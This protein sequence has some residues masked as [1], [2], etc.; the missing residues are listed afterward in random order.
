MEQQYTRITQ[1]LFEAIQKVTN[2]EQPKEEK[3]TLLVEEKNEQQVETQVDEAMSADFEKVFASIPKGVEVHMKHKDSGEI[4][5]Q[6][7]IGTHSAVAAAKKHIASMEKKGYEIHAKKLIEQVEIDESVEES[8]GVTD[9]N[10]KSQGGTRKELLAKYH[11]TK[12]P[13]DAEAARKAG[14]TQ[15]ELQSEEVEDV[16]EA[17]AMKNMSDQELKNQHDEVIKKINAKGGVSSN[18]RLAQKARTIRTVLAMRKATG[19]TKENEQVED[20][21][22]TRF[23]KGQDVGA[24]GMNFKK[25]AASAAKRYGSKEAGNRVAGA[26]LKKVMAKEE[27]EDQQ[28]DETIIKEDFNFEAPMEFTFADYLKAA[29][30]LA[31]SQEG[32]EEYEIVKLAHDAFKV[33]EEELVLEELTRDDLKQKM[34][35]HMDAGHMISGEK[36]SMKDGKPYGEYVVTDK[37]TGVR[38]KYIHHGNIRRVEN[39]GTRT[40]KDVKQD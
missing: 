13:K 33:Q 7:F 31:E 1:S 10:P 30:S 23:K 35:A 36:F 16:D 34:K 38:R 37:E 19:M 11:K 17:K 21:D 18:D 22:E 5:K 6:K 25:I 9:Y 2:P 8:T 14:A 28:F 32:V 27:D 4:H 39:M 12:N 40:K 24:P 26:V 15:K 29:T 20:L 3:T